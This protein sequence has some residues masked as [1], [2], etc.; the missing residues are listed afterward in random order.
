MRT[1]GVA[2]SLGKK[3]SPAQAGQTRKRRRTSI[4]GEAPFRRE[5]CTQ[6]CAV[7]FSGA[8]V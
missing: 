5:G 4:A 7:C 2:S 3:V 8:V 1:V 6:R